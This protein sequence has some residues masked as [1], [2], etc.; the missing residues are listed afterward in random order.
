MITSSRS[1]GSMADEQ[2]LESQASQ[3]EPLSLCILAD[4][5]VQ[6]DDCDGFYLTKNI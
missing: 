6:P 2:N 3:A 5:E 1:T 4:G